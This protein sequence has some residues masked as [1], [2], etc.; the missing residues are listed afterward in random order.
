M[1]GNIRGLL[2]NLKLWSQEHVMFILSFVADLCE[3][4]KAVVHIGGISLGLPATLFPLAVVSGLLAGCVMSY[5]IYCE[6]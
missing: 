5:L 6:M 4:A 3:A 2:G 1:Q